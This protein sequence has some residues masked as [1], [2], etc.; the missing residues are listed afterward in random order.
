[1]RRILITTNTRFK[2]YSSRGTGSANLYIYDFD[3]NSIIDKIEFLVDRH[4]ESRSAGFRGLDYHGDFLYIATS[5]SSLFILDPTTYELIDELKLSK[6]L[7]EYE[8]HQIKNYNNILYVTGTKNDTLVKVKDKGFEVAPIT[9]RFGKSELH[10][11]AIDF[12]ND[13]SMLH[14]YKNFNCVFNYTKNEVV[15]IGNNVRHDCHDLEVID[16]QNFVINSSFLGITW[17]YNIISHTFTPIRDLKNNS[18]DS[19]NKKGYTRGVVVAGNN[20]FLG[21][22]PPSIGLYDLRSNEMLTCNIINISNDSEEVIFDMILHKD[23]WK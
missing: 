12:L 17:I 6:D 13:G 23:D 19:W 20:I 2:N 16:D 5:N 10:F 3:S 11:N 4:D 9:D 8:I 21:S 15:F 14:L 22:N 1:M 18:T 7:K